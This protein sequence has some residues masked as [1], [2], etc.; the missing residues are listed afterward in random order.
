MILNLE[1]LLQSPR[2]LTVLKDC[3]V[4]IV[5]TVQKISTHW[6]QTQQQVILICQSSRIYGY[7]LIYTFKVKTYDSY[8]F[9]GMEI[10]RLTASLLTT[11][12]LGKQIRGVI[13]YFHPTIFGKYNA[14]S[15]FPE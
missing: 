2:F 3:F 12:P 7:S 5:L 10:T 9:P 8:K 13:I 14:P 11:P 6:E 4:A 1:K 15:Q